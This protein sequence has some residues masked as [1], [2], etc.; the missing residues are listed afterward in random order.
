M[1][2]G[3][4]TPGPW[5][6]GEI[7]ADTG[8]INIVGDGLFIAGATGGFTDGGAT[9]SAN[10]RLIAEAP[11]LKSDGQFLLDRL[12]EFERDL[13]DDEVGRQY[14]GHVAPA[15]TR[16]RAAIAKATGQ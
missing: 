7:D 9:Q 15:V 12:D 2:G 14:A 11:E 5:A 16:F 4:H 3:K 1:S 6:V 13:L 10:A 8:Q